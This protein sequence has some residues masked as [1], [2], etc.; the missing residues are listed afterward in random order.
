MRFSTRL[1]GNRKGLAATL[2]AVAALGITT[3]TTLGGFSATIINPTNSF[4]SG[5]LQLEESSGAATCYSAGAASSTSVSAANSFSC[6]TINKLG[7][8]LLQ[9]PGG[10]P[11]STTVTLTNVGNLAATTDTLTAGTCTATAS[12]DNLG[13]TGTD[14]AGFC[15]MVDVTIDNVTGT[16]DTCVYPTVSTSPCTIGNTGTLATLA[17][18]SV[19]GI[20]TL[21][22][23]KSASYK[24]TVQL[25][26]LAS[27]ADQG[28]SANIPLTWSQS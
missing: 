16:S 17:S 23:G 7:N 15:G 10:T 19:S 13:W 11:V 21:G 4:A 5:T 14:T 3:A 6:K 24:F 18:K 9:V 22:V 1:F 8:A 27:N 26:K 2:A 12:S 25:D 28:L 20:T